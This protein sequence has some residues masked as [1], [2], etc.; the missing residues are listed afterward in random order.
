MFELWVGFS[1]CKYV[2]CFIVIF[3]VGRCRRKRSDNES[4]P[5]PRETIESAMNSCMFNVRESHLHEMF[6]YSSIVE[7]IVS[8]RKVCHMSVTSSMSSEF[9]INR[10]YILCRREVRILN[11]TRGTWYRLRCRYNHISIPMWSFW[12]I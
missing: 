7:N 4:G 1:Y 5:I 9:L 3:D 12:H 8:S 2:S 6:Q 11:R 10:F